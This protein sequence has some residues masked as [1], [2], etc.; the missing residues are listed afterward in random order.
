[1]SS[2]DISIII[3]VATITATATLWFINRFNKLDN[4][5]DSIGMLLFEISQEMISTK[6]VSDR[7]KGKIMSA[8]ANF[9]RVFDQ[10]FVKAYEGIQID[11]NPL[12]QTELGRLKQHLAKIKRAEILT[13]Q[14]ARDFYDIAEKIK[15]DRP[16]DSHSLL[17]AGLAGFILGLIIGVVSE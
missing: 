16:S 11:R 13:P 17:L 14:E 3:G 5:I 10:S 12:S 4:K 15:H 1:M 7:T 8:L 6:K 2:V 9:N